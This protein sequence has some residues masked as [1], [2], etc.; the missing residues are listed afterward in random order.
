MEK[1]KKPFSI[2]NFFRRTGASMMYLGYFPFAS[3]TLGSAVTVLGVWYV[4]QK[5]PFFF[6]IQHILWYW[7]AIFLVTAISIILSTKS[8]DVFGRDD[9]PQV[10]ID[11]LAGQFITFFLIPI[12][13]YTL[14][15][16]FLLF[17]FFDI[18]KPFPVYK[19]E[20]MDDGVGITMDD[21]AAGVYA[22]I[23]LLLILAV[24]HWIKAHL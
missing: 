20:D 17:R 14:I 6:D 12:S 11:E 19:M 2:A 21:V 10:I 5:F 16:G 8:K 13:I 7:G 22:N 3:G 15:A 4:H 23:S 9:P 18:V 24:Y 1:T